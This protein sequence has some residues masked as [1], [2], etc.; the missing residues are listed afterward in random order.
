[1][2]AAILAVLATAA[3]TAHAQGT[4]FNY[5][6]R[7]NDGAKAASG[8]YDLRFAIYDASSAGTQQ[9]SSLTNFATAVSNGL[10]TATLDFGNQFPG[11]DRWL[12]IAVRTNGPSAF[13]TLNPRQALTPTP[14]AITA[15]NLCGALPAGQL[16]GAIANANLP[17]S[18]NFS[19]AVAADSFAG[20]GANVTN[21]NAATLNGA[22]ASAF[23]RLGGNAVTP[24]QFLGST[25][26]QAVEIWSGGNRLAQFG[27]VSND[28][29]HTSIANI[30]NGS[31]LN[32]IAPGSAGVTIAGGGSG[33]Y[34]GSG[35]P[36]QSLS[37]SE[38][39][40]IGGGSQNL[41]YR[42]WATVAG[43]NNNTAGGDYSTVAG[44]EQNL[45]IGTAS[46]IGGGIANTNVGFGSVIAGG[47]GNTIP[48]AGNY[49]TIGGGLAN[50]NSGM[51]ATVAGGQYNL[52]AYVGAT[53]GGGEY[54]ISSAMDSSV[55][56]GSHN[57]AANNAATIGGGQ[58]NT[59]TG[60]DT[61]IGGGY[62]NTA[63]GEGGV[64][65]GGWF[66]FA[67]TNYATVPGGQNN[68]A[69]GDTS[70]AAGQYAYAAHAGTF[71]WADSSAPGVPFSTTGS[72]QFLIRAQGG[73]G[74]NT[75]NPGGAALNVNGSVAAV[76]FAG[77][78]ANV[79][80]V[81]AASLNGQAATNFWQ[82]GGNTV[83]TGQFIGSTN[84]Q[85]LEL[86]VAGQRALRME[87][88]TATPNLVGGY[89][90]NRIDPGVIGA[91]I[92]G[93]GDNALTNVVTGNYGTV[94]GGRANLASGFASVAMGNAA[95]AT[96][97]YATAM[98]YFTLAGGN[99]SV[100]MGANSTALGGSATA[101]G[102]GT[103]ASGNY[104][105]AMG[106]GTVAGGPV[107]LAA[108]F[109]T[110]A[111][112]NYSTALG[113]AT[114][115]NG[116]DSLAAGAQ[117]TTGGD[118]AFAMGN[119]TTANGNSAT[120]L[121]SNTLAN[122]FASMALGA[123]S[124][125]Y[126]SV[127]MAA[128]TLAR[129]AHDGT[130]VWADGQIPQNIFSSTSTN[131]FLIRAQGGVGINT[132]NPN[133]AALNINGTAVASNFS[134][135]GGGLTNVNAATLGGQPAPAFAPVSNPTF[136][137]TLTASNAQFMGLLRAGS[138]TGTDYAPAPAGLVIRRVNSLLQTTGNIVARTDELT[139]ERD[140]SN[141]GFVIRYPAGASRQTINGVAQSYY[142]TNIIIRATLNSPGT[143]GTIQLLTS[144]QRAVHADISFGNTFNSGHCTKI[145]VDRYDDG[146][147]SDYY[148]VGTVTSTYNQ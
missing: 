129:A 94:L 110:T 92:A 37:P 77:N 141:E 34:Y 49:N 63:Q 57:K 64:V 89:A 126:G 52:A 65:G 71:V 17:A 26:H 84:T 119:K 134:G 30:V 19:G 101:M 76:S 46:S 120:A 148:W 130:F 88:T 2:S 75:N 116:Y 113:Y 33:N 42:S 103:L 44:G 62:N 112:G 97:Y 13:T 59:A 96:N 80:N 7:L 98:G 107:A 68:A 90:G 144:A 51:Q 6:G 147:T 8:N 138:E 9:G 1:M 35:G 81:N 61:V 36:N 31:A 45:S 106:S 100:A 145:S 137:G 142:G 48:N 133:G 32:S 118:N 21:V 139:L 72:N 10:F 73:V 74:I 4:T 79:T 146:A 87:P 105:T 136:A 27:A 127:S 128:G 58:H 54:N 70:F 115:A 50:T 83:S 91:V 41:V 124:S 104:S 56:G 111:N 16:S 86:K 11:A 38:F 82:L 99:S 47:I 78:G 12:E 117:T 29:N 5:Q 60:A 85:A 143:A 20:N 131:Q 69:T 18:P 3:S 102:A 67:G 108:G 23:W 22:T 55:A 28:A 140:G 24:G 25:N 123:G 39:T 132:N 114:T 43:G 93:G 66:N 15:G 125:A 109:D 135:N 40:T 14:Y 121:G 122:A 95:T 53:V